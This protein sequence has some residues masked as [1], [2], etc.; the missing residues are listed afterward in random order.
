MASSHELS[1]VAAARGQ[2]GLS[3]VSVGRPHPCRRVAALA[4]FCLNHGRIEGVLQ[5]G[6]ELVVL[7]YRQVRPDGLHRLASATLRC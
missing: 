7:T 3:A 4:R 1:E 2:I 6:G 5:I